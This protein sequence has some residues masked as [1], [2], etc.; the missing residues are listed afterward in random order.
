MLRNRVSLVSVVGHAL[1]SASLVDASRVTAS[2]RETKLVWFSYNMARGGVCLPWDFLASDCF[3]SAAL[4][5]YR[6][7]ISWVIIGGSRLSI[8]ARSPPI[9]ICVG[10]AF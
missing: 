1:L 4:N 9:S 10:F 7:E 8:G 2:R 6:G 3:F 5:L